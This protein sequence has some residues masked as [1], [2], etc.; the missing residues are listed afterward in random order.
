M[1]LHGFVRR[2]RRPVRREHAGTSVQLMLLSFAASVGATRLMLELTGYPRLAA[3]DLHIAHVLWG[4]L[5]LFAAALLP[6]LFAN[7][8]VYTA[9]ALA[10][11]VGAGLFMDEV[12]KFITQTNDYFYPGAAPIVYTFF[13]LTVLLYMQV[14]RPK[15]RDART[16]LYL[17]LEGLEEV[18]DRDLEPRER[19]ALETRLHRVTET[20]EAPEM[21]RLARELLDYLHSDAV[22]VAETEPGWFEP[23]ARRWRD[24]EARWLSRARVRAALVGGLGALGGL[25]IWRS[26]PV[27]SAVSHPHWVEALLAP[28]VA[29][30]RVGG[31]RALAWF[32]AWLVLEGI[33]G[34]M[35]VA[36]ALALL[37]RREAA[38]IELG[39]LGL[40]LALTVV[41]LMVFY[42]DQ[43]ST[44]L[45]AGV[46][47]AALLALHAFRRRFLRPRRWEDAE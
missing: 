17:A 40:L 38:G 16:E 21:A 47:F 29:A 4:G 46:Q 3:G 31:V 43:F 27:W 1:T 33:I 30:G 23:L 2:I 12:G 36:A 18:L 19:E 15:P 13:L 41:D 6:I 22:R 25:G 32:E 14:R 26:L 7:R 37:V 35:L 9:A 24:W 8:W 39:R 45:L 5:L 44:I 11:G 10:A 34:L 20:A 28:L 42:F